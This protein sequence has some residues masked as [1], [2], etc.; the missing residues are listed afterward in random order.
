MIV[1]F[2]RL[3][4]GLFPPTE[5][6]FL[7]CLWACLVS[8]FLFSLLTG[9]SRWQVIFSHCLRVC[10]VGYFSPYACES[11]SLA[12]LFLSSPAGLSRRLLLPLCRGKVH[13]NRSATGL[14]SAP[15]RLWGSLFSP[16]SD[17]NTLIKQYDTFGEV[18]AERDERRR[19]GI[20]LIF[21]EADMST[22]VTCTA[23]LCRHLTDGVCSREAIT[24]ENAEFHYS[25][26]HLWEDAP[27]ACGDEQFC[28][29]FAALPD[30]ADA[31]RS[32]STG[33]SRTASSDAD[34][35]ALVD[36]RMTASS[37]ADRT[38]LADAR[39][40]ALPDA[41][42][43][44]SSDAGKVVSANASKPTS[45]SADRTALVDARM[46]ALPD[47]DGDKKVSDN[48]RT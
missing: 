34:R 16:L 9:S 19:D 45:T 40:K 41:S 46:T 22:I 17:G 11:I 5:C 4:V 13:G 2:F 32:P 31:I 6:S 27:I 10:P 44:A 43:I 20:E 38:A 37:D 18:F 29:S 1:S 35:T 7:Y 26:F 33:A 21:W 14:L 23:L 12:N 3:S 28:R 48:A 39:M 8:I 30:Y 36:A 25:G 47:A 24:L 15:V 42:K